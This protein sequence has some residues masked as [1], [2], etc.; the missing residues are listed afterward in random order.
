MTISTTQYTVKICFINVH[1]DT[2]FLEAAGYWGH[3][4][5]YVKGATEECESCLI[6]SIFFLWGVLASFMIGV[7]SWQPLY[8]VMADVGIFITKYLTINFSTILS[9]QYYCGANNHS[10]MLITLTSGNIITIL[11]VA[12]NLG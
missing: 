8:E 11:S 9:L 4:Y 3:I 2:R 12:F 1:K 10:G 6:L 5:L 7:K